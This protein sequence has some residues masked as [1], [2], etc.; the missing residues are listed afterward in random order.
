MANMSAPPLRRESEIAVQDTTLLRA[1]ILRFPLIVG[2]V[3]IHNYSTADHI[4]TGLVGAAHVSTWVN[5]VMF[6]ISEGLASAAVP[7]FLLISGYLFFLNFGEWSWER[8]FGKLKRRFHTLL[9]PFVFWNLVSLLFYTIGRRLPQT[10]MYFVGTQWPPADPS[11]LGSVGAMFGITTVFPIA[12]SFW[13]IRDLM[14]LILLAPAIHFIMTRRI[15][16][17]FLIAL[18]V[19][20]WVDIWP[21]LW[22]GDFPTF[23]F[24]LG[25]YLSLSKKDVTYLDRYGPWITMIFLCL[26]TIR[27]C[28][29][30]LDQKY[31]AILVIVFGVPSV[32]WLTK[33]A[34]KSPAVKLRLLILSDASFFIFAAHGQLEI[35]IRKLLYR[36]VAPISGEAILALY[37]FIPIFLIALLV[38]TYRVLCRK[39]PWLLN[40]ISGSSYRRAVASG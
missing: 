35:V 34:I 40:F 10:K 37:F 11:F 12:G 1:S 19:L 16:L 4:G 6:F 15:A 22:P 25:A 27:F 26:I 30:P 7:L 31:P 39:A 3:Y 2:V 36:M 9:I 13:F 5:F 32:W 14:A 24:S 38:A 8:Y 18:F 21:V 23:F 17:A 33:L 20:W 29:H 28:Y